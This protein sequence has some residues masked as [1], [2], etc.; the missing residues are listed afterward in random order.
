MD[1]LGENMEEG[2]GVLNVLEVGDNFQ[3]AAEL[4]PL[5]SGGGDFLEDG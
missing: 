3:P 5:A 2:N 4:P 1:A